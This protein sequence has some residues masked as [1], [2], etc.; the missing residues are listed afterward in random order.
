MCPNSEAILWMGPY[1][2]Q[3]NTVFVAATVAALDRSTPMA[4]RR[5]STCRD[6]ARIPCRGLAVHEVKQDRHLDR[7][8]DDAKRQRMP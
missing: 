7:C 1:G 5:F 4:R 3:Q 2:G 6:V 8:H